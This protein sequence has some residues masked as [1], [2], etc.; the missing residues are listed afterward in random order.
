MPRPSPEILDKFYV[1]TGKSLS[2]M[3]K[4]NEQLQEDMVFKELGIGIGIS[5][6]YDH[7]NEQQYGIS[8]FLH[9]PLT[10]R[11]LVVLIASITGPI[12]PDIAV[13]AEYANFHAA[14]DRGD[15]TRTVALRKAVFG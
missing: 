5:I 7:K 10:R 8:L 12:P 13:T 6:L 9:Q 4:L 1:Q 2:E 3:A 11:S 14:G 15:H